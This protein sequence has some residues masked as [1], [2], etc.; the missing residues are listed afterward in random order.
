MAHGGPEGIDDLVVE[1]RN[2]CKACKV[3]FP[4]GMFTY[5]CLGLDSASYPEMHSRVKAAHVRIMASF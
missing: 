4:S 3:R 5:E 1:F 2:W